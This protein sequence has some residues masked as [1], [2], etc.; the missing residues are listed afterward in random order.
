V[1]SPA[2]PVT[3][4][5]GTASVTVS[6]DANET[7]EL[8]T[9]Q[10]GTYTPGASSSVVEA[11]WSN[12]D[13]SRLIRL[14]I[15][16]DAVG[17][18]PASSAFVAIGLGG[19]S[20]IDETTYF[21]DAFRSACMVI[22]IRLDAT[23]LEGSFTCTDL[24]SV[25]ESQT[26]DAQ[27]TF[28]AVAAAPSPSAAVLAPPTTDVSF[29]TGTAQATTTG[30]VEQS[31][32]AELAPATGTWTADSG[33]LE[34]HYSDSSGD[35]VLVRLRVSSGVDDQFIAIGVPGST[36]DD[37]TYFPDGL[38]TQCIATLQRFDSAGLTG[39]FTCTDVSNF[40][41]D[42]TIDATGSFSATP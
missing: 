22:I 15:D 33:E 9:D 4:V 29:T 18:V 25:D 26:I 6:G 12:D 5:D 32:T 21:P 40:T 28:A 13:L 41:G 36:T 42:M 34:L 7:F 10:V 39:T 1:A 35:T 11:T 30:D 19:S 20:I 3:L 16:V 14:T 8:S 38:H 2:G 31:I 23:G 17:V 27:G 37:A 24:T